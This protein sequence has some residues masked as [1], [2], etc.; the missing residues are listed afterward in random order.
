MKAFYCCII[1]LYFCG[2][3]RQPVLTDCQSDA[4]ANRLFKLHRPILTGRNRFWGQSH[5]PLCRFI[6]AC[7]ISFSVFPVTLCSDHWAAGAFLRRKATNTAFSQLLRPRGRHR[8]CLWPRLSASTSCLS[9]W[10][11]HHQR[12]PLIWTTDLLFSSTF[13]R[14]VVNKNTKTNTRIVQS[15]MAMAYIYRTYFNFQCKQGRW[16]FKIYLHSNF[17]T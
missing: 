10:A 7:I 11:A 4:S 3:T 15:E 5:F 2:L 14:K 17:N 9:Q 1:N 8:Q 6:W 13:V 16:A 12:Q